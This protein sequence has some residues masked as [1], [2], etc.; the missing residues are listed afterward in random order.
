MSHLRITIT[1]AAAA[2]GWRSCTQTLPTS[3]KASSLPQ[4]LALVAQ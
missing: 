1:S 4:A 3:L 2:A